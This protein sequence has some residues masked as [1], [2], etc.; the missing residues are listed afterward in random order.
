MRGRE[1]RILV[2]KPRRSLEQRT[3][4][5]TMESVQMLNRMA[6]EVELY[7]PSLAAEL[8]YLASRG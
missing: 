6:C 2:L 3:R 7:Q 4:D 5:D 1:K 8:R